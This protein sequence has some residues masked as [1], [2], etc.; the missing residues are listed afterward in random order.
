MPDDY[1]GCKNKGV[2]EDMCAKHREGVTHED[3]KFFAKYRSRGC[4]LIDL[5]N[6][7]ILV[8][9]FMNARNGRVLTEERGA[10]RDICHATSLSN[11]DSAWMGRFWLFIVNIWEWMRVLIKVGEDGIVMGERLWCRVLERRHGW[12]DRGL[13]G[14]Y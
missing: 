7:Y 5:G 1:D 13:A 4:L 8:D 2:L 3:A 12:S 9:G 6:A 11:R 10:L 14:K